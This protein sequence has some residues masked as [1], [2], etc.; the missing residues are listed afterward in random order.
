[1][2]SDLWHV[3]A[4]NLLSMIIVSTC[5]DSWVIPFVYKKIPLDHTKMQTVTINQFN[6]LIGIREKRFIICLFKVCNQAPYEEKPYLWSNL[7]TFKKLAR[8]LHMNDR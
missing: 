4:H 2:S 6:L 1:M 8:D 5:H 7:F 3:R